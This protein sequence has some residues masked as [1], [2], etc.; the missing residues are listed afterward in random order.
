MFV[1]AT[2]DEMEMGSGIVGGYLLLLAL[3]LKA[4][5]WWFDGRGGDI[6][7]TGIGRTPGGRRP[8]SRAI[9][10]PRGHVHVR[11]MGWH[12]GHVTDNLHMVR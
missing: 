11:S 4:F 9:V 7:G 1:H 10:A 8:K 12:V 2:P 6:L 5:I 3:I